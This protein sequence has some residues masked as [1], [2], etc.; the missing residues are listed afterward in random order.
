M[1]ERLLIDHRLV[2]SLCVS[3]L[4]SFSASSQETIFASGFESIGTLSGRV[5]DTNAF[6]ADGTE[7][8]VA[9]ATV[10]LLSASE[11]AVTDAQG[12][13]SLQAI[14]VGAQVLDIDATTAQPAPGGDAYAGFRERIE[15]QVGTN[16]EL[17]PFYLPRIESDSL[18]TVDP[19]QV[20]VVRNDRMQIT[21]TAAAGSVRDEAGALFT[22]QLSISE[23]PE[24]LAPAALPEDMG[25]GMLFT[26]QPVGVTFEP[27]ATLQ[28]PNNMDNIN[29][30]K[31]VDFWSLDPTRGVFTVVGVG[32]V[33]QDG[34]TIETVAG[35]VRAAD[36]HA[37]VPPAPIQPPPPPDEPPDCENCCTGT[38]P[39][40][41]EPPNPGSAPAGSGPKSVG[42]AA[43]L[44]DGELVESIGIPAYV[45]L[46]QSRSL[47]LTYSSKRAHA[48]AVMTANAGIAAN[49][50]LPTMI[51]YQGLIDD[52][53]EGYELFVDPRGLDEDS[54]E[55]FRISL[56]L[57][58]TDRPTGIYQ[59]TVRIT[60]EYAASAPSTRVRR[61]LGIVNDRDS[62]YGAGWRVMGLDRIHRDDDGG[63]LLVD[64]M[65]NGR[66]FFGGTGAGSTVTVISESPRDSLTT[67]VLAEFDQMGVTSRLRKVNNF[68]LTQEFE[69]V[70][71][72]DLDDSVLVIWA[73][74]STTCVF[75]PT[76]V[77]D[78][79]NLINI[80]D[81]A[82]IRGIPILTLGANLNAWDVPFQS[83]TDCCL[84]E[85]EISIYERL[86]NVVRESAET[87]SCGGSCSS[88]PWQLNE[89]AHPVFVGPY[90]DVSGD[91]FSAVAGFDLQALG[92]G[93][94]VLAEFDF[95]ELGP[96]V[97]VV[98]RRD[99]L[100]GSQML[101]LGSILGTGDA[102]GNE[103]PIRIIFRNAV[104][105]LIRTSP[106][107]QPGVLRS[108]VSDSST[109]VENEDGTYT[110]RLK[111]GYTY[112]F[113][114]EGLLRTTRDRN[115]NQMAFEYDSEGSLTQVTDPVGKVTTLAYTGGKLS[116]ITGP[117]G[118]TTSFSIDGNGDLCTVTYPDGTTRQFTYDARHLLTSQTNQRGFVTTYAYNAAG[119]FN[120]STQ[121]DG[122]ERT[123]TPSQEVGFVM[124]MGKKGTRDN[125]VKITRPLK[126]GGGR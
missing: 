118:R 50:P 89:P 4:I 59:G 21:L 19:G 67:Q 111:G 126:S 78:C 90:G 5:L 82:R 52:V 101:S 102:A 29:P 117:A 60:S 6:V 62:A 103:I 72:L 49:A 3:L 10:R 2:A 14:P 76:T 51:K 55:E 81:E 120:G 99:P 25:Q 106:Q 113:D 57:D 22:G 74:V 44:G 66:Q 53:D 34:T 108:S 18:T 28:L 38:P 85:P 86:T 17:R 80:L 70:D 79:T 124:P 98:T 24:S 97:G 8:G 110:R 116:A 104:D 95:N 16:D 7:L 54:R 46:N 9:G 31:Q 93:E 36:W 47:Q 23:V 87:A 91:T 43:Y 58:A 100:T 1:R 77:A 125:P 37:P 65:G 61:N 30:G 12:N 33:S 48:L 122:S 11:I 45:S 92:E 83:N 94:T 73:S 42:S 121:P 105:W 112:E 123:M 96:F 88:R 68:A 63:V 32:E 56:P 71:M 109:L 114:A 40:P 41:L 119:Q 115:G 84:R 39:G 64:G 107:G 27:P 35:G 75:A 69:R 20:T 26:I 13:F 15:L